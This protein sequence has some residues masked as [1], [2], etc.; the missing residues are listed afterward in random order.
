V[1]V[2]LAVFILFVVTSSFRGCTCAS[3]GVLCLSNY[4]ITGDGVTDLLV[5]RDDG[6]VEVYGY[7]DAAE[8]VLRFNQACS[9]FCTLEIFQSTE[10]Y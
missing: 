4:D 8:P 7:N 10:H 6:Q 3:V 1:A 9:L 2:Y 5:G